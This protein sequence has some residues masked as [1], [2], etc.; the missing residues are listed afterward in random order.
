[1]GMNRPTLQVTNCFLC[2]EM[3]IFDLAFYKNGKWAESLLGVQNYDLDRFFSEAEGRDEVCE[4]T[5][6]YCPKH[7]LLFNP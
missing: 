4:I 2:D 5:A 7:R 3:L 1:M 6:C